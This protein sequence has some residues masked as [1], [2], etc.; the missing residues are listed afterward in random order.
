MNDTPAITFSAEPEPPA[1]LRFAV[2]AGP[3]ALLA[4]AAPVTLVAGLV[5]PDLGPLLLI[6][7]LGIVGGVVS[8][9][10]PGTGLFL[11]ALMMYSR[12]SEVLTTTL[13]VPSIA[14]LFT[15][16]LLTGVI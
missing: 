16:W 10:R 7:F 1:W 4:V 6:G 12:A 9:L 3:G 15:I 11:F 8:V 2:N 14:P 5:V 13:G